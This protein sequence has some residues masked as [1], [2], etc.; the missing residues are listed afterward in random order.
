MHIIASTDKCIASG[1][2]ALTCP[3]VF[4]QR[5]EDGVVTLLEKHPPLALLKRVRQAIELCPAS[6]F[7][8]E[9]EEQ[10]TE[11]TIIEET[12]DR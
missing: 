2:C 8:L 4:G 12:D 10:I 9:D 11:L 1:S 3:E 6:V 5:D 7:R